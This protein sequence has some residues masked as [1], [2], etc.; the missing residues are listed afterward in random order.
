MVKTSAL[1]AWSRSADNDRGSPGKEQKGPLLWTPPTVSIGD[2]VRALGQG[3]NGPRADDACR[4]RQDESLGEVVADHDGEGANA[5]CRGQNVTGEVD[6]PHGR[7]D[8]EPDR[9]QAEDHGG[10]RQSDGVEHR[11][12]LS[13]CLGTGDQQ[14]AADHSYGAR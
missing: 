4:H 2:P 1:A 13:T 14:Q 11:G 7:A 10:S 8:E 3:A 9:T 5:R 6:R 12:P